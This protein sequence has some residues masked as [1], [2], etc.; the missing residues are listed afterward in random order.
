[1]LTESWDECGMVVKSNPNLLSNLKTFAKDDINEE[2]IELLT[3]YFDREQF[4]FN[5]DIAK[6]A[7]NAGAGLLAWA[8][9]IFTYYEKSKIVKPKRLMLEQKSA[10][11]A[12]A[13]R[14]LAEAQKNLAEINEMLAGLKAKFEESMAKK[15]GLEDQ[16]NKTKKQ[17]NTA[18]TLIGSL[19]DEQA[20]WSKGV[21]ELG[22]E[23]RRLI[24]N[25]SLA[26]A[27]ISYGGP[28][29]A[30]FRHM[31]QHDFFIADMKKRSVPHSPTLELTSFLVDEATVGEWNI[32][33]LPKD[34]LS[35]QNGIMVCNSS[36]YPLL[37]DP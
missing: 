33:G 20:R 14:S 15:K 6:N 27:F 23:K 34:D 7:S 28:F 36:R 17:I 16:A 22:D 2:T 18:R 1:M 32:Q 19:T 35:I 5:H 24:G 4:W 21:K 13:M 26:T 37:I 10:E 25:C 29:D 9:A 31:L 30:T 8:K 3:P 11:L 12:V